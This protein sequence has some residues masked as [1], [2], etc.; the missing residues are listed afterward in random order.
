MAQRILGAS[1]V[2]G[3]GCSLWSENGIDVVEG[4]AIVVFAVLAVGQAAGNSSSSEAELCCPVLGALKTTQCGSRGLGPRWQAAGSLQ[5]VIR[6]LARLLACHCQS[7]RS[8][9]SC[10]RSLWALTSR[11]M[12]EEGLRR[13]RLGAQSRF[14]DPAKGTGAANVIFISLHIP[15]AV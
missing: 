3:R 11:W 15:C 12:V 9:G 14:L 1:L 4:L 7:S 5:S 6:A 2:K 8:R 10:S 13:K